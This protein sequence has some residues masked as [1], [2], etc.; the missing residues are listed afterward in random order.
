MFLLARILLLG[1][2]VDLFK[3]HEQLWTPVGLSAV[4]VNVI[5]FI[6]IIIIMLFPLVELTVCYDYLSNVGWIAAIV[7]LPLLFSRLFS[8]LFLT[9]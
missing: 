6:V 8:Y 9:H 5:T 7:A 1:I 3:V 2:C 4:I